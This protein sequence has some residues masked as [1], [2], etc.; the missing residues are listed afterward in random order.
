MNRRNFA[1]SWGR[2]MFFGLSWPITAVLALIYLQ[3]QLIPQGAMSW[4]YYVATA[5]GFSGLV[6]AVAYF[7]LFCPV[8][9]IFPSYYFS[10]IWGLILILLIQVSL[11]L[12]ALIFSQF[13]FH[14]NNFVVSIIMGEG[15]SALFEN[16]ATL[17]LVGLMAFTISVTYWIQGN[18][19]WR[20]MQKRFSNPV[21]N[22]YL[23]VIVICLAISHVLYQSADFQRFGRGRTLASLFPLNYQ[24]FFFPKE[25]TQNVAAKFTYPKKPINCTGKSANNIFIVTLNGWKSPDFSETTTPFLYHL[26]DHGTEFLGHRYPSHNKTEAMFALLYGLP[27]Y[28]SAQVQDHVPA[29]ISEAQKR[30]YQLFVRS[31]YPKFKNWSEVQAADQPLSAQWKTWTEGKAGPFFAFIDLNVADLMATDTELKDF[32][33]QLHYQG[34]MKG[35]AFIVTGTAGNASD[36]MPLFA[37]WPDRRKGEWTHFTS[38]HDVSATVMQNMWNCKNKYADYSEGKSLFLGPEKDWDSFGNEDELIIVDHKN[39]TS[40]TS[41]W[42]GNISSGNQDSR[43]RGLLMTALRGMSR[44]YR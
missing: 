16:Q 6:T 39:N 15:L 37:I 21:K 17:I 18:R 30:G 40:F 42:N 20:V 7:L 13:R 31:D 4:A 43:S 14:V 9:A 38:H 24:S 44:F 10:R 33:N 2:K 29:I 1:L 26:P 34:A 12:D 3:S 27:A 36:T 35:S 41:D 28:F 23:L 5:V 8:I 22:W 32:M 25:E 19:A 11:V